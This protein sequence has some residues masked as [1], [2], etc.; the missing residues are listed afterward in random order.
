MKY[1][2]INQLAIISSS[3]DKDIKNYLKEYYLKNSY[4]YNNGNNVVIRIRQDI[5]K[6]FY[7]IEL[8][9]LKEL[10]PDIIDSYQKI[11]YYAYGFYKYIYYIDCITQ[12]DLEEFIKFLT[13][14]RKLYED[15]IT[16]PIIYL[17][18]FIPF[19][20]FNN[21]YKE[22]EEKY[23]SFITAFESDVKN[24]IITNFCNFFTSP[25]IKLSNNN[26]NM[27][28]IPDT[29][30]GNIINLSCLLDVISKDSIKLETELNFYNNNL[31]TKTY[32][33]DYRNNKDLY[34]ID[35]FNEGS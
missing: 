21:E 35:Q 24:R 1:I 12:I 16:N 27:F 15:Y 8:H 14:E 26:D 30:F 7:H 10:I 18:Q 9:F 23:T 6:A 3:I 22:Y 13:I 19:I 17:M 4:E 2:Y 28:I 25:L 31:L 5:L 20:M 33:Y 32:E 34:I 29:K 11:T